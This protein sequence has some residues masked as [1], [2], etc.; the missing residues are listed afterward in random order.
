MLAGGGFG[1]VQPNVGAAG[2]RAAHRDPRGGGG[3]AGGQQV[4][5]VH[6]QP[7]QVFELVAAV[8]VHNALDKGGFAQRD[9]VFIG[10]LLQGA[11]G[12][13]CLGEHRALHLG[14]GQGL[15]HLVGEGGLQ[16]LSPGGVVVGHGDQHRIGQLV[17]IAVPQ[18][19]AHQGVHRHIQVGVFQIH[20]LQNDLAVLVDGVG[21]QHP[22]L[23]V[24][25]EFH[26][27]VDIQ[28][29]DG[30][31]RQVLH[32]VAD[33]KSAG[34]KK[35]RQAG[36][37]GPAKGRGASACVFLHI[38]HSSFPLLAAGENALQVVGSGVF[39]RSAQPGFQFLVF[40]GTISPS[41]SLL[42]FFNAR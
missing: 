25:L 20:V 19:S 9:A 33:S 18:Q 16:L 2:G 27:G 5:L 34:D 6:G 35:Q 26:T 41:S 23:G 36:G 29:N 21:F 24:Y 31:H 13:H 7:H 40:H 28:R 11:V 10:L 42:S 30:G 15:I 8:L 17:H 14:V 1:G 22:G 39:Q 38:D 3:L 37:D 4:Q 12:V 32:L